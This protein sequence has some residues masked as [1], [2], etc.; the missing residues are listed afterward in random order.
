MRKIFI[1]ENC[2]HCFEI[3]DAIDEFNSYQ[4]LGKEIDVVWEPGDQWKPLIN[5]VM[6]EANTDYYPVLIF[7]GKAFVGPQP[8]KIYS[9]LLKELERGG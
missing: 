5:K 3:L 6:D 1:K 9:K 7:D 4:P 2:K 8:K